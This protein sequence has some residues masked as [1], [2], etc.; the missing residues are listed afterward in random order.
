MDLYN[1]MRNIRNI[2]TEEEIKKSI[3]KVKETLRNITENKRCFIYSS[4]VYEE[5]RNNHITSRI[6]STKDLGYNYEHR[7][8]LVPNEIEED[9][10]F[11]IDLTFKQ[12]INQEVDN[13]IFKTLLEDGYQKINNDLWFFYLQYATGNVEQIPCSLD[14]AFYRKI[15]SDNKITF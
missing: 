1:M 11:L 13:V 2:N 7:F 9:S 8:V 3:E 6:I 12:F 4:Y 5:L 10:Y 14:N 15:D